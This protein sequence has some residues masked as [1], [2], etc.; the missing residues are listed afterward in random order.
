MKYAITESAT[1]A[2]AKQ[3]TS[4]KRL[5]ILITNTSSGKCVQYSL[6]LLEDYSDT[7]TIGQQDGGNL[8]N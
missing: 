3:I 1:N 7:V 2:I 8:G 4:E 5:R 6:V